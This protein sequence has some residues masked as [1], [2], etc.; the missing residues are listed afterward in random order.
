MFV[1][2]QQRQHA[3]RQPAWIRC[4]DPGRC[5]HWTHVDTRATR[6]AAIEHLGNAY[7]ERLFK[8]Q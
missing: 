4:I 1:A 3:R 5:R 8:R 2:A 6:R 7:V